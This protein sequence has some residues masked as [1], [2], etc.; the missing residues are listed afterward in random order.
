MSGLSFV[1]TA[2]YIRDVKA[3]INAAVSLVGMLD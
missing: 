3:M 2:V 1:V